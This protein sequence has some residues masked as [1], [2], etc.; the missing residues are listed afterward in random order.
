MVFTDR[1]SSTT[2]ISTKQSNSK[3]LVNRKG[4]VVTFGDS[5]YSFGSQGLSFGGIISAV[6]DSIIGIGKTLSNKLGS[7]ITLTD[8]QS[9]S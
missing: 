5:R 8:K 1:I 3:T 7:I 2:D 4:G 6:R 9:G